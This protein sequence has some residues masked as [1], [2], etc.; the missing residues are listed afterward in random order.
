[1]YAVNAAMYGWDTVS[2]MLKWKV[3]LLPDDFS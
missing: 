1:M 2:Y 3:L